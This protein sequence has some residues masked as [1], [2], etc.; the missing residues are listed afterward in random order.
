MDSPSSTSS[1]PCRVK[2]WTLD[3]RRDL[4]A[5]YRVAIDSELAER[6]HCSES[7]L[8]AEAR[9]LALSK[10][11]RLFGGGD[12]RRWEN[13]ELERLREL[14]PDHA[15]RQIARI[16]GRSEL[17]V[18]R[19]ATRLGLQKSALRRAVMAAEIVHVR[20]WR[21]PRNTG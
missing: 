13:G 5:L 15:T 14:Y 18:L 19:R 2:V 12:A 17:S 21:R 16:L 9:R 7:E 11:R 10:D 6:F 8:R 4:R 1:H 20:R 3:E